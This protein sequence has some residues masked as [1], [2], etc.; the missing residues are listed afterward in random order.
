MTSSGKNM[1][2]EITV[3]N[4]SKGNRTRLVFSFRAWRLFYIT[5]KNLV[6]KEKPFWT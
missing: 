3:S 6:S 4:L 2:I 5:S 1:I